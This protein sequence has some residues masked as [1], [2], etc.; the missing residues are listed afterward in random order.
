MKPKCNFRLS[1]AVG[2]GNRSF[3]ERAT[4][5]GLEVDKTQLEGHCEE[6]YGHEHKQMFSFTLTF[7]WIIA[8]LQ[9]ELSRFASC[10]CK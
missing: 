3:W 4:R 9:L 6:N 10:V 8:R 5:I 2:E 7:G 1:V